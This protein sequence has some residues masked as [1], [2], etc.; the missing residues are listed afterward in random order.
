VVKPEESGY[1]RRSARRSC[2]SGG[3]AGRRFGIAAL[4][5]ALA[6]V[7]LAGCAKMDAALGQQWIVVQLSPNTTVGA[8]RQVAQ[9][10]SHVPNL[11]LVPVQPT[12]ANAGI[13]ESV[14][15]SA[16]NAS[17]ANMAELQRC[18]QRFPAVVQGFT[19]QDA[20]DS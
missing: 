17:D 20:G 3:T 16:T 1:S 7:S 5:A 8:A 2:A 19:L 15:Y 9:A 13:V 18:L 12:S 4:A 11:R 6:V 10:C 14:R